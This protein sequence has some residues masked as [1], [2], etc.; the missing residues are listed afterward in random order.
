MS[1]REEYIEEI[2][3]KDI[4]IKELK[5]IIHQKGLRIEVML[6]EDWDLLCKYDSD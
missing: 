1:K 3:N 4:K 5:N 6:Q 2:K